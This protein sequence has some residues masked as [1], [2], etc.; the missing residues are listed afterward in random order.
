MTVSMRLL[1]FIHGHTHAQNDED[2]E[3]HSTYTEHKRTG[4]LRRLD[5]EAPQ[6]WPE[7]AIDDCDQQ[8]AMKGVSKVI[9]ARRW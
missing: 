5:L 1:R 7:L 9:E 6:S 4:P 3:Y 2:T 8:H